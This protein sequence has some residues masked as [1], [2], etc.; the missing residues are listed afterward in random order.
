VEGLNRPH[1]I[2]SQTR[3]ID[4]KLIP[5]SFLLPFTPRTAANQ[6][7]PICKHTYTGKS[8]QPSRGESGERPNR[9]SRLLKC[10]K[11]RKPLAKF[12]WFIRSSD[13]IGHSHKEFGDERAAKS[14]KAPWLQWWRRTNTQQEKRGNG[15]TYLATD[16][17]ARALDCCLSPQTWSRTKVREKLAKPLRGLKCETVK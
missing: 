12:T 10:K 6:Y 9:I 7:R 2:S 14:D 17:C 3:R 11:I 5:S 15:L 4:S 8:R 13:Q 1:S 16:C